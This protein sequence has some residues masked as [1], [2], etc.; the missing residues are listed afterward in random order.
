[1]SVSSTFITLF[2]AFLF[3]LLP[4]YVHGAAF[5]VGAPEGCGGARDRSECISRQCSWNDW[6]DF[7]NCREPSQSRSCFA[8]S[9][10]WSCARMTGC[11]W[12]DTDA[13]TPSEKA[14]IGLTSATLAFAVLILGIAL[15]GMYKSSGNGNCTPTGA[16]TVSPTETNDKVEVAVEEL[17]VEEGAAN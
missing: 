3:T 10:E 15:R 13:P 9:T 1:M 14:L 11:Q 2:T 4:S 6:V 8:Q 17:A 12:L 5:C 16:A 7:G